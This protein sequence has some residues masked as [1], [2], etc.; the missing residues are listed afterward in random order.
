[1]NSYLSFLPACYTYFR[2]GS[3]QK[4]INQFLKINLMHMHM[5]MCKYMYTHTHIIGSFLWRTLIDTHLSALFC[6]K[7]PTDMDIIPRSFAFRTKEMVH[8]TRIMMLNNLF[9]SFDLSS[10]GKNTF[11]MMKVRNNESCP[12]FYFYYQLRNFFF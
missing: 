1:M 10:N 6:L 5:Y 12:L 11:H 2:F 8:V 3:P 7:L 4:Y 9:F